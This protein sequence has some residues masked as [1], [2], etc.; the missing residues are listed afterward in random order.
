MS[1]LKQLLVILRCIK[2]EIN[3]CDSDEI[4]DDCE[5]LNSVQATSLGGLQHQY[6]QTD[7]P[8]PKGDY[9]HYGTSA[10]LSNSS[11]ISIIHPESLLKYFENYIE[12]NE[13]T[14]E[15]FGKHERVQYVGLYFGI[16]MA[17][18]TMNINMW[19]GHSMEYLERL[20]ENYS[21]DDYYIYK[22]KGKNNNKNVS[23]QNVSNQNVSN[24]VF[25]T[26]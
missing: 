7:Y 19:P 24:H 8:I 17:N 25:R 12:K 11:D 4:T 23:N 9:Y 13:S 22:V 2:P 20:F 6:M 5:H 14:I 15:D 3:D 1:K 10:E 21:I 18:L 16:P 26:L